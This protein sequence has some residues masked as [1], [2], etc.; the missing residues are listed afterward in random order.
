MH[1]HLVEV[2]AFIYKTVK[3]VYLVLFYKLTANSYGYLMGLQP[4]D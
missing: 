4:T 2:L 1:W 3:K